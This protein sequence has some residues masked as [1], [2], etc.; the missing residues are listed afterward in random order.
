MSNEQIQPSVS[1]DSDDRLFGIPPYWD[2]GWITLLDK[3]PNLAT[4]IESLDLS[5][6]DEKHVC[7]PISLDLIQS[8][9]NIVRRSSVCLE[10]NL[11]LGIIPQIL[12]TGPIYASQS[13]T[14][15][16]FYLA[17]LTHLKT[18][19][20]GTAWSESR[21]S[22]QVQQ[23]CEQVFKRILDESFRCRPRSPSPLA[24]LEH[25]KYTPSPDVHRV[26]QL[27]WIVPFII[28]PKLVKLH[29]CRLSAITHHF[30]MAPSDSYLQTI[31]LVSCCIDVPSI[32]KLLSHTRFLKN[33]KYIHAVNEDGNTAEWWDAKSFVGA[34]E[35]YRRRE[36]QSL[37]I[38]IDHD[39]APSSIS[40]I[41]FIIAFTGLREVELDYRVIVP[42]PI[43]FM[44]PQSI[45][46]F[47]LRVHFPQS[48][49]FE[50]I[51]TDLRKMFSFIYTQQCSNQPV[52]TLPFISSSSIIPI[53]GHGCRQEDSEFFRQLQKCA[54]DH[55][56]RYVSP[57]E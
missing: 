31:E 48:S 22:P 11:W 13:K 18:L 6:F 2:G 17:C 30:V 27:Q 4:H 34:I 50:P 3:F 28:L 55:G 41:E 15:Q 24:R 21:D 7:A 47:R 36:L 40:R 32:I 52:I 38:G 54:T 20:L 42:K 5:C 12:A 8:V 26:N 45:E 56:V 1:D 14:L 10:G 46:E 57:T 39:R 43:S 23:A 9:H 19:T 37:S 29:A 53:I 25:L 44:L 51:M 35:K 49:S 33:F 16:I